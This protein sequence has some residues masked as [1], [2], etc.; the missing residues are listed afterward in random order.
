MSMKITVCQKILTTPTLK[1]NREPCQQAL[2]KMEETSSDNSK[3]KLEEYYTST[4][5]DT[6][7]TI[8]QIVKR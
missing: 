6:T 3:N 1:N 2:L 8:F 4:N 7:Y 5:R